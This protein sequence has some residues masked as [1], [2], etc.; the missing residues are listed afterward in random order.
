M[1][2]RGVGG[3]GGWWREGGMDEDRALGRRH[4]D[5]CVGL[6]IDPS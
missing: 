4:N 2:T 6:R 1:K 3:G 5:P